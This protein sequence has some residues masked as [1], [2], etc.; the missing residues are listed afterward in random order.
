MPI[1]KSIAPENHTVCSRSSTLCK[2][3]SWWNT[4]DSNKESAALLHQADWLL[5]LLHG[6]LGVTDY[7]NALKVFGLILSS[8]DLLP[9]PLVNNQFCVGNFILIVLYLSKVGY[10]PELDSYPPWLLS[11]S[12][13]QL[14]PSVKAPGTP[15]GV[16]KEDI[17]TQYGKFAVLFSSL[18][19]KA[20]QHCTFLLK[21]QF[22]Y[23]QVSIRSLVKLLFAWN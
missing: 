22:L 3:V 2:L 4:V 6:K 1:V 13:S 8:L 12:Y 21:A 14:L 19:M 10:D 16:L 7:N 11:Q 5:W 20:I 17:R 23:T 15:I 9:L 18:L